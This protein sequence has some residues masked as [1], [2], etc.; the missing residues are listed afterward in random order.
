MEAVILER[1][2]PGGRRRFFLRLS[3]PAAAPYAMSASGEGATARDP[4]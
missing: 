2:L 1:P 3:G 4:V